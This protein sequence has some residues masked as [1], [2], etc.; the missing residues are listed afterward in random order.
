METEFWLSKWQKNEIGFHL[1][2]PHPWLV[3]FWPRF[4]QDSTAKN[5][6][7]PLCGKTLDIDYLLQ[8]GHNI[9]ANELSED[10]IK[11][12]FERIQLSPSI[13][14]W[15]GGLCYQAENI[16]VYVGD[17]FKLDE[18][19]IHDIDV[20]YDRAAIIA[21]PPL[22]RKDYSQH[23]MALTL[24][25]QQCVITLDYDQALMS[26]PPFSVTQIELEQH[27]ANNY[28]IEPI[29]HN[30]IIEHEPKFKQNGLPYLMQGLYR[31]TAKSHP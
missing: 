18:R 14:K 7:I 22:M 4:T 6:F 30:D 31:L 2:K 15:A 12:M 29:K 17:F 27:Y 23:I 19:H 13:T 11:A 10:A 20:V 21:L 25:A 28:D 8:K 1:A 26:G 16:T 3:E 24:G 5:V 9:T